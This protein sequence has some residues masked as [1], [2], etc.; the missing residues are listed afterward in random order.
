MELQYSRR[1]EKSMYSKN[2]NRTIT[3]ARKEVNA[4]EVINNGS[5]PEEIILNAGMCTEEPGD[6]NCWLQLD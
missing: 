2:I 6:N 1:E 5:R 4:V 3:D